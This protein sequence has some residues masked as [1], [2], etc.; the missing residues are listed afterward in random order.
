MSDADQ[1]ATVETPAPS[2]FV[3]QL[4]IPQFGILTLML[5]T[6]ATAALLS[7]NLT[8]A[9]DSIGHGPTAALW[10]HRVSQTIDAIILAAALVGSGVLIQARCYTM[11]NRLQPGHW[12]VMIVSL[13]FVLHIAAQL[14]YPVLQLNGIGS[15][16]IV[17]GVAVVTTGL[18]TA[19]Y[20]LAFLK[21]R[22]AK[23]WKVLMGAKA[24]A[25]IMTTLVLLVMLVLWLLSP[26]PYGPATSLA[27][28]YLFPSICSLVA[29]LM[30]PVVAG[31]DLFR[32][33][34]RDWLHW[35]GVTIV[36]IAGLSSFALQLCYVLLARTGLLQ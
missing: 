2:P 9:G 12:L 24:I 32:N 30:L 35:L 22:D 21:L 13:E 36:L 26:S 1:Q 34:A 17:Q 15:M 19:A 33:A 23:R 3:D 8:L 20:V 7:L 31:L 16:P 25:A 14:L 11:L 18:I 5:W 6:A 10:V 29:F 27:W 4:R 28:I